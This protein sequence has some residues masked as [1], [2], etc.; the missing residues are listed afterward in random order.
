MFFFLAW[1]FQVASFLRLILESCTQPTN[2]KDDATVTPPLEHSV[3][4]VRVRRQADPEIFDLSRI[5]GHQ[6]PVTFSPPK[7]CTCLLGERTQYR[8][9]YWCFRTIIY[10]LLACQRIPQK[11][12]STL[13]IS[14]FL[15][16]LCDTKGLDS[17]LTPQ[18]INREPI[19]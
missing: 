7:M 12:N 15:Q 19:K 1:L 13:H 17:F 11:E 2:E 4:L 10:V 14:G 8:S 6:R 16:T 18:A 3:D 9:P 5:E